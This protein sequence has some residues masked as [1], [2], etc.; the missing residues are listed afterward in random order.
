MPF[1]SRK[2]DPL[3]NPYELLDLNYGATDDEISKAFKKLMFSLHPDKQPLGQSAEEAAVVAQKLH[4]V[5][6]AKSFL[7]DGEYLTA[8]REYDA[9]LVKV[10]M[11]QQQQQPQTCM[12]GVGDNTNNINGVDNPV[13]RTATTAAA[14][15]ATPSTSSAVAGKG[16]NNNSDPN[17]NAEHQHQ[18]H[19]NPIANTATKAGVR[20]KTNPLPNGKVH[21]KQW[22]KAK[23]IHRGR[24]R[25]CPATARPVTTSA[26][27]VTAAPA[28]GDNTMKHKNRHNPN[29]GNNYQK[30]NNNNDGF[31]DSNGECS[32][33]DECGSNS[34][35]GHNN[36]QQTRDPRGRRRTVDDTDSTNN[37]VGLRRPNSRKPVNSNRP[38]SR[39]RQHQHYPDKRRSRS[40]EG[41]TS[42]TGVG[43]NGNNGVTAPRHP[44]R[45]KPES[46]CA[47]ESFHSLR[48]AVDSFI[49]DLT[50]SHHTSS[51]SSIDIPPLDSL[52]GST[53]FS[54]IGLL[55]HLEVPNGVGSDKIMVQTW[56]NQHRKNSTQIS[57]MVSQFNARLHKVDTGC[58]LTFRNMNGKYAFTLT[59]KAD[60]G[61]FNK[62]GLRHGI[63][64][65]IEMSIKLHNLINPMDMKKVDRVRLTTS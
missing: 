40:G 55:F 42:G 54:Y 47:D 21:V 22:G 50:S 6:D 1:F 60:P 52:D 32:T 37:G 29:N 17:I 30:V 10:A 20:F 36:N 18:Q 27:A 14:A 39:D 5:M 65:F 11:Q 15:A 63:E 8:R 46:N 23:K 16:N 38:I 33:T 53:S 9:N 3:Q 51:S 34:D 61:Q 28:G 59:K 13:H 24:G 19:P 57:S 49:K 45:S 64:Y 4:D 48:E 43:S 62:K 12:F 56:F 31:N 25:S 7:L 44:T 26:G 58:R 41:G 2:G 35:D